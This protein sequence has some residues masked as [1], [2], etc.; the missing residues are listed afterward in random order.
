LTA[1]SES[2]DTARRLVDAAREPGVD[3]A[4]LD[5]LVAAMFRALERGHEGDAIGVLGILAPTI[6]SAGPQA[7]E[8]LSHAAGQLI[9]AGIRPDAVEAAIVGRVRSAIP[10]AMRLQEAAIGT[11][12]P[13]AEEEEDD[14]SADIESARQ[15]LRASM[16]A[17]AAAWDHLDG[18]LAPAAAVFS[19]SP[20][21]R[22]RAGALIAELSPLVDSHSTAFWLTELL[23]V[24]DD[25]PFIA[26]EPATG[27]GIRGRMS[28]VADNGQLHVLLMDVFPQKG[29]FK[30]RRVSASAAAVARGEGPVQTEET[31]TGIWNLYTGRALD[32]HGRLPD[33]NDM[34]ATEHWIWIEG[35]PA[36]IPRVDGARVVLLGPATYVRAWGSSRRFPALRASLTIEQQLDRDTVQHLLGGLPRPG[37]S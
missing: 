24:L 34:T 11:L 31:V 7:A 36:D 17:E 27:I 22:R 13:P 15:A 35:V 21:A 9:E 28:G 30:R 18:M 20:A 37:P 2:A 33:A 25:E 1:A 3:R 26:I 14:R 32:R 16:P 4:H 5:P 8:V 23:G 6:E 10:G 12:A 29:L 19:K